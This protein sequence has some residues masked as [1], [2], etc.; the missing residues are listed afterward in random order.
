MSLSRMKL[1]REISL[2]DRRVDNNDDVVTVI[3]SKVLVFHETF[4]LCPVI[5][6][7]LV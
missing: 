6:T 2:Y 5:Y 3:V 7:S 4:V 1:F